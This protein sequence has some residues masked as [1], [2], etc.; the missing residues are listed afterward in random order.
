[1]FLLRRWLVMLVLSALSAKDF[2]E[3]I[4][5]VSDVGDNQV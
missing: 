5:V 3:A 4:V 1:M 2:A